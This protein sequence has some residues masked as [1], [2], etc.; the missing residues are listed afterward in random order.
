MLAYLTV[1]FNE[2]PHRYLLVLLKNFEDWVIF[3]FLVG[4]HLNLQYKFRFLLL[5]R[6]YIFNLFFKIV[7]KLYLKSYK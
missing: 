2:T 7:N 5:N 3:F 4:P 1:L 6:F